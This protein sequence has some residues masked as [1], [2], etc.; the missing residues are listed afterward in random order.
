M[1]KKLLAK[2]SIN[3]IVF[4]VGLTIENHQKKTHVLLFIIFFVVVL[5]SLFFSFYLYSINQIYKDNNF[6][7]VSVIIID[8]N[9]YIYIINIQLLNNAS[10][11]NIKHAQ[12]I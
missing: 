8:L 10:F 7:I 4:R 6:I 2:W 12:E 9:K 11:Q 3:F 1:S 5:F